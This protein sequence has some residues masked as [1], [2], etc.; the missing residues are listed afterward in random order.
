MTNVTIRTLPKN[1]LTTPTMSPPSA[2]RYLTYLLL[3]VPPLVVTFYL[4]VSF[5]PPPGPLPVP[6]YQGLASL[7]TDSRAREVYSE[8]WVDGGEG[9]YVDLPMGRTRYWL[10]GPEKGKKIV[11]IHGL[12]VPAL[13]WGPLVPPL[14]AAGHRVLLYDLY[15]RG[16][17]AA[18]VGAT[19]DAQLYVT[20][21]ALLLQHL[22]W[23]KTRVGGVSM[24]GAIAAAFVAT[25][26]GLVESDVV[27]VSSAG[28]VEA[29][30]LPRTAKVMSSPLIQAL[31]ANQFIS[32]Y[33]RRL[34][35]RTE[36]DTGE[37]HEVLLR[38]LVRLQ[39]AHLP[40]FNRA[41]SSSLRLGPVTGMRWAFESEHWNGKRVLLLHGTA[42]HT[43]PSAHSA[44][45]G[46]LIERAGRNESNSK[47]TQKP[48]STPQRTGKTK[49]AKQAPPSNK[50]GERVRVALIADAGHSLT[51]TH[52]REVGEVVCKFLA[53]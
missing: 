8:N 3:L 4:L 21:L 35:S 9:A 29:S 24:G 47:E 42:D 26:P 18:P 32:A 51:W 5:P 43:V 16:Y 52:S 1:A 45:I 34:A 36:Q 46:A 20:Q 14:V 19:Y 7:P 37:T 31:T 23:Q 48:N 30:D 11:L 39:S 12:S 10:V 28:L 2:S 50:D 25:F 17:S 33:L 53:G 27:L 41:V 44:R 15:G 13:I 49:K 22:G 6:S 40:G 38:E